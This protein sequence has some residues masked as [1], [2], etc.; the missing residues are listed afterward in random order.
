MAQ[1]EAL[2]QGAAGHWHECTGALP[3]QGSGAVR[4]T[5]ARG[6]R[7]HTLDLFLLLCSGSYP[8]PVTPGPSL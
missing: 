2:A 8:G 4:V 5:E 1:A 3:E 6:P 7:V